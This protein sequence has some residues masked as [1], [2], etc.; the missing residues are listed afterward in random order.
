LLG[1]DELQELTRRL[2]ADI[3]ALAREGSPHREFLRL[4]GALAAA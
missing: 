3:A 4:K 2:R 1:L